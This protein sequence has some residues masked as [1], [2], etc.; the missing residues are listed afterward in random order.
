MWEE[1]HAGFWLGKLME[2]DHLEDTGVDGRII[3]RRIV[4]NGM[5]SMDWIDLAQVWD[6]RRGL[7]N[8]V[9]NDLLP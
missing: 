9:I 8:A 1:M 2:I 5:E 4:M 3:L 7:V 6:R